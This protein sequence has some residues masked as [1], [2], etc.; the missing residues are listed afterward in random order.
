M[1]ETQWLDETE[2]QAWRAF[3]RAHAELTARLSR[4]LLESDLSYADFQVLVNLSEL[5]EP[6]IRVL[7][8]AKSLNW[9]KSRMSHQLGRMEKRGLVTRAGCPEDRRGAFVE[10]TPA[11]RTAIERAAPGHVA[12]V[13]KLM[14]DALDPE[15]VRVLGELCQQVLV[16]IEA[17]GCPKE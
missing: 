6:R 17:S 12:V 2:Q 7:E 10:L 11:G 16:N 4:Q 3:L 5:D 1:T 8:L 15:Q 9:E 13:R 14:F